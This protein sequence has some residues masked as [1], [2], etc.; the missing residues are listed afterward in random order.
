MPRMQIYP[1]RSGR[2]LGQLH[3]KYSLRLSSLGP[4]IRHIH[5]LATM[6]GDEQEHSAPDAPENE[7]AG[8]HR[9]GHGSAFNLELH[10]AGICAF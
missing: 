3:L 7:C 9:D 2:G 1:C 10:I 4:V 6:S 8:S 5:S